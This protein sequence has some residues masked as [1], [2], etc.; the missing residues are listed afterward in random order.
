MKRKDWLQN[1]PRPGKSFKLTYKYS[2]GDVFESINN[3]QNLEIINREYNLSNIPVYYI[4]NSRPHNEDE[5]DTML[6]RGFWKEI[7]F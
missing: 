2:I 6:K 1:K 4:K 7:P 3:S 5:I